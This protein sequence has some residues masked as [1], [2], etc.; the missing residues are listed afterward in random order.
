MDFG[1]QKLNK[2]ADILNQLNEEL[3]SDIIQEISVL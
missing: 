3:G 1:L 2:K